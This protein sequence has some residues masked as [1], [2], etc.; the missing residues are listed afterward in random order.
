MIVAAKAA[1]STA[2][3]FMILSITSPAKPASG[4]VIVFASSQH[5]YMRAADQHTAP[6]SN[7]VAQEATAHT[8]KPCCSCAAATLH[9]ALLMQVSMPQ[10]NACKAG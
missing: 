10:V 3:L 8:S 4:H 6:F 7:H 5:A 9:M 2:L 1:L